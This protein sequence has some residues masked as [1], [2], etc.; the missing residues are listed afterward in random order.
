MTKL[1]QNDGRTGR[2][3]PAYGRDNRV[4]GKITAVVDT[5]YRPNAGNMTLDR[6][7]SHGV[8]GNEGNYQSHAQD[9]QNLKNMKDRMLSGSGNPITGAAPEKYIIP[10]FRDMELLNHRQYG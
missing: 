3:G 4:R 9:Q 8:A 10:T 2:A 5:T 1:H 7:S 6:N